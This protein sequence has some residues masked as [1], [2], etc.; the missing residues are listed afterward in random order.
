LSID[1]REFSLFRSHFHEFP[2]IL[3]R[4]L[5][6]SMVSEYCRECEIEKWGWWWCVG[7]VKDFLK[8]FFGHVI[9]TLN[10]FQDASTHISDR[11]LESLR[12][13]S[14]SNYCGRVN[15]GIIMEPRE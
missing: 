12:E 7:F 9:A 6:P 10:T 8:V 4:I 13:W 2:S 1:R 5:S 11:H 14:R 3:M 15:R